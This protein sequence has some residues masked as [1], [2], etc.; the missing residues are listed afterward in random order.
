VYNVVD[1]GIATVTWASAWQGVLMAVAAFILLSILLII[2]R[3]ICGLILLIAAYYKRKKAEDQEASVSVSEKST[4]KAL[5]GRSHHVRR[6]RLDQTIQ[7]MLVWTFIA[8]LAGGAYGLMLAILGGGDAG[9]TRIWAMWGAVFVAIL[10]ACLFP[11]SR[12]TVVIL[13]GALIAAPYQ[14]LVIWWHPKWEAI[15]DWAEDLER[16]IC[17]IVREIHTK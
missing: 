8:L 16:G 14:A 2:I 6:S 17:P 7:V 10:S 15:A 3:L 12:K 4:H 13:L 5:S 11:T 1:K 9:S